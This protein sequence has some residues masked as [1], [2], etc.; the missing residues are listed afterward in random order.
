MVKLSIFCWFFPRELYEYESKPE[1][2]VQISQ[3]AAENVR[4]ASEVLKAH[5]QAEKTLQAEK[6]LLTKQFNEKIKTLVSS[7]P[8]FLL[9]CSKSILEKDQR[10]SLEQAEKIN[11]TGWRILAIFSLRSNNNGHPVAPSR[12]TI[13]NMSTYTYNTQTDFSEIEDVHKLRSE[14]DK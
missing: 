4:L 14:I 2:P 6:E 13:S 5:S 7:L 8:S 9:I 10:S 1:V 3:L 11:S 12:R